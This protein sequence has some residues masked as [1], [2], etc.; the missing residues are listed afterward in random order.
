M[1]TNRTASTRS[2]ETLSTFDAVINSFF[3]HLDRSDYS[4][5]LQL[6]TKDFRWHRQG[7]ELEG[8]EGVLNA[9]RERPAHD[10]VAHVIT[11]TVVEN[12]N[13]T[14][15]TVHSYLTAYRAPSL[16][17]DGPASTLGPLRLSHVVTRLIK[18]PSGSWLISEQKIQPL[19]EFR[20]N[21]NVSI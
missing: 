8:K 4:S 2:S 20:H 5:L 11:N 7:K 19:F 6:A 14:C 12:V 10:K 9:L 13:S 15:A 3:L 17:E 18:E 16:S 1:N 21:S